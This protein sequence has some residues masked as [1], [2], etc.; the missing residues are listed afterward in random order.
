M[1]TDEPG[2]PESAR[3][4]LP[5]P[6]KVAV[7]WMVLYPVPPLP[8]APLFGYLTAIVLGPPFTTGTSEAGWPELGPI[9]PQ[10][11]AVTLALPWLLTSVAA[12]TAACLVA[13]PPRRD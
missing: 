8:F 2:S 10:F 13:G 4:E 5:L 7:A 11:V 3:P 1:T 12:V 6:W 9:T